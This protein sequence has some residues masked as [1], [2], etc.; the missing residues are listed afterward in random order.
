MSKHLT[1]QRYIYKIHS[2]R[3][4]RAKW[5][6]R[7]TISQ[8]R[9]NKELIALSDSQLLRFIDELNGNIKPELRISNLKARIKQLKAEENL[10]VS[11]P[12][13]KKLYEQLDEYQF[14]KD[15]VC[16]VIDSVKDYR[17]IY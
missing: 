15:Y 6:L 13:I 17:K 4:R 12:R 10:S 3:L 7:L 11:R 14:Q 2:A 5:N 1:S 8:A 9:E 16:V